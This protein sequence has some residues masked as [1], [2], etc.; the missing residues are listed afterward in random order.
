MPLCKFCK[1]SGAGLSEIRV[2]RW[3]SNYI[4]IVVTGGIAAEVLLIRNHCKSLCASNILYRDLL[5]EKKNIF[6]LQHLCYL[7]SLT[8]FGRVSCYSVRS[9]DRKNKYNRHQ[10]LFLSEHRRR[11]LRSRQR[12]EQ[13]R[14]YPEGEK[15]PRKAEEGV[16]CH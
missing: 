3:A 12:K 11:G 7:F 16:Y 13:D 6:I 10:P 8:K 9:V 2:S 14:G 4:F 1:I 5:I 15:K